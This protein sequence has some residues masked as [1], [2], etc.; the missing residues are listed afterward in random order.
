MNT[1]PPATVV[2][3][4]RTEP[5]VLGAGE[6]LLEAAQRTGLRV[7]HSCRGGNCGSCRMTLLAGAVDYPRRRG[8]LAPRRGWPPVPWK[9]SL[10]R[11][12]RAV[13]CR[14][15]RASCAVRVKWK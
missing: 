8:S 6:T 15:S 3:H 12:C 14:W 1:P 11:P 4:P 7:P 2:F 13:K 10:V 9:F 5:V